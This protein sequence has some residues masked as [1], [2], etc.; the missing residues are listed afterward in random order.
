[1]T[2]EA[3]FSRDYAA[4]CLTNG[5]RI[6]WVLGAVRSPQRIDTKVLSF[7]I[8]VSRGVRRSFLIINIAL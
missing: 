4:A 7:D 8:G 3:G 2:I 1:M 5:I 6:T